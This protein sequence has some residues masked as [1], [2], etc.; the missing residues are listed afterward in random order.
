MAMSVWEL[1]CPE[2]LAKKL[3]TKGSNWWRD[4]C[5]HVLGFRGVS[6]AAIKTPKI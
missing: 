2:G 1:P 4:F 5:F 3:K 6:N